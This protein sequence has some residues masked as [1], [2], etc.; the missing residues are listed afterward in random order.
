MQNVDISKTIG[1]LLTK[2]K[3][4]QIITT[5]PPPKPLVSNKVAAN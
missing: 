5:Y 3:N 2:S 1:N 4:I